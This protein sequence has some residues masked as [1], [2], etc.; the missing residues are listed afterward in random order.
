M[1]HIHHI[2]IIYQVAFSIVHILLL[3][4][5][6]H[7]QPN[8][9][10]SSNSALEICWSKTCVCIFWS[11]FPSVL[12][13]LKPA[14]VKCRMTRAIWRDPLIN[15]S[16]A[17][18]PVATEPLNNWWP[19]NYCPSAWRQV[20]ELGR[21]ASHFYL[22]HQ[23][24]Q[25]YNQLLKPTLSE[26]ELFRVFSLSGEFRNVGVRE[27]E[28]LELAKLMER[29]P[30]PIK[31]GSAGGGWG[32]EARQTDGTGGGDRGGLW[33]HTWVLY[34]VGVYGND[35]H[36]AEDGYAWGQRKLTVRSAALVNN[37]CQLCA[38]LLFSS[39]HELLLLFCSSILLAASWPFNGHPWWPSVDLYP[40][41]PLAGVNWG[42]ERQDQHLAAGLHLTAEAGRLRPDGGHGVRHAVGGTAHESHLRD[43]SVT[44]RCT[45][46]RG[47]GGGGGGGRSRGTGRKTPAKGD[48]R[49]RCLEVMLWI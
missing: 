25:T 26:I 5:A 10:Y 14:T 47:W 1:L 6:P 44:S 37:T 8:W 3:Y 22:T 12:F 2:S 9:Q 15:N 30:V 24:V 7:H 20:T 36:W 41:P 4:F 18:W 38:V 48:I 46:G 27:E 21:I 23:T 35:L 40:L 42:A 49:A 31:V 13:V 17:Q 34:N 43:R 11:H 19:L 33:S 29:V 32:T 28:K 16:V 45:W 39:A